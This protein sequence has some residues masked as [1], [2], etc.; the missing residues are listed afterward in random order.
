MNTLAGRANYGTTTGKVLI[1]GQE[2]S[3][4]SVSRLVGFVPQEDTMHRELTVREIL[5]AYAIMRLPR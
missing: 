2:N 3:V 4:F 1:N 5:K